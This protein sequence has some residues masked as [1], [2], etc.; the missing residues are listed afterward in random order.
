MN[1]DLQDGGALPNHHALPEDDD[2]RTYTYKRQKPLDTLD[3]ACLIINKMIGGGIFVTSS[4]VASLT[5]SKIIALSL[6]IFGGIYS[7]CR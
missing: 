1:R 3:V 6:W 2:R 5:Q 4:G 7:F